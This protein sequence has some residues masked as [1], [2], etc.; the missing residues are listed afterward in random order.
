MLRDGVLD[1]AGKDFTH[2]HVRDDSLIYSGRDVR[3]TKPTLAR[4]NKTKPSEQPAAPEVMEQKGDLIIQDLWQQGTN[5]FH[6]MCVV[7]TDT[8]TYQ[9]K[10]PETCLH[11]AEKGKKKM[12]LEA[13]LQQRRKLSP[14]LAL[15]DGLLGGGGDS[16]PEQDS[17]S[18]GHQLES[19]LLKE[20]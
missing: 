4:S 8:L 7:N 14:F 20:V 15:V 3:T 10:E 11:E 13:C 9:M 16:Y 18:P 2:S 5:S 12:Y 17:Q 1:L 19:A 6:D